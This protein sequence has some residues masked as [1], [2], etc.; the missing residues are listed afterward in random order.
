[1]LP[2]CSTT[3][4]S[5]KTAGHGASAVNR[6]K[7]APISKSE[8]RD[9][10]VNV[11]KGRGLRF[12]DLVNLALIVAALVC[13]LIILESDGLPTFH[14]QLPFLLVLDLAVFIPVAVA[15]R[16]AVYTCVRISESGVEFVPT[17]GKSVA[18]PWANLKPPQYPPSARLEVVFSETSPRAGQRDRGYW[19]TREMCRAILS[20]PSCSR[21]GVPSSTLAFLGLEAPVSTAPVSSMSR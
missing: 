11:V 16:A 5:Y 10:P 3:R 6:L 4:G 12:V 13:D 14:S 18:I 8:G 20:H 9:G 21:E 2:L 19:V 15:N 7:E 1:M 17:W